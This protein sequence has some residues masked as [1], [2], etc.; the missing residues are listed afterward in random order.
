MRGISAAVAGLLLFWAEPRVAAAADV[1]LLG[2]TVSASETAKK[3]H[4]PVGWPGLGPGDAGSGASAA[5]PPPAALAPPTDWIRPEFDDGAWTVLPPQVVSSAPQLPGA[6][7]LSPAASSSNPPPA[8]GTLAPSTP[9]PP[10][11]ASPPSSAAGAT[12]HGAAADGG[13]IFADDP[14]ADAGSARRPGTDGGHSDGG[15]A[16]DAGSGPP[17]LPACAGTLYLRRRFA[18]SA[19]L[20]RF[21]LL[22]LRLRYTDGVVVYLNGV[23]LVRRRVAST[24][25]DATTLALERGPVEPESHHL[26]LSPGLLMPEGNVLAVEVHPRAIERC[27]RIDLE[28][29][30]SDGPR[31]VRGPYIE[32]LF[33]GVLDL[34]LQTNTPTYFSVRYG[35]GEAASSRDRELAEDPSSPPQLLHRARITG[36]RPGTTYHYQVAITGPNG[37][38]SELPLVP[39]HTPP[40][41]GRPLR[42]VV[43]GD[44][45]SGHS[46]HAQVVQSL[47]VEDPDL[48]LCTGDVVERGTEDGDW[49]RYFAVA[50]PLLERIPIFMAPGNHE[51]ALRRQGAQRLFQLWDRLFVPQPPAAA[52]ASGKLDAGAAALSVVPRDKSG[53]DEATL[54]RG[55]YSFDLSSVHFVALD[56]N[57]ARSADQLRWLDA[58]LSRAALRRPRA[59]IVWM[60]DGPYSMGWHGDNGVLIRDYVPL[61]E[62]H[63]VNLVFSGHDHDFERGRRGQLNYIVTGGGGA[64]LRPLKC[65]VPGK[66]RCKHPPLAFFNEHN[67]VSVEVLP[68]ALRVCPKRID[69]TALEPCQILR[70]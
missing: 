55:Y 8:P 35:K 54:P 28:L 19:D 41:S 30:L 56:S 12:D 5:T 27:P 4:V 10:S 52:V 50:A 38:R 17:P 39:L 68:D 66:R 49:D 47:L 26:P 36:L 45:R 7:W 64:E 31:V 29:L 9:T 42:F 37:Q 60:H 63:R 51:Y 16:T 13:L 34:A 40:A 11:P 53:L 44:S 70:R 59:I 65:G 67:Y 14:P 1:V 69:G 57:Q 32:R 18:V 43:Y 33:G 61:F 15:T 22:T 58:D 62:K 46:V 23:E 2:R 21:S 25:P 20:A 3:L 24:I 48:I 6:L